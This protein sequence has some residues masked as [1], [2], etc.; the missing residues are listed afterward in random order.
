VSRVIRPA[1]EG[2]RDLLLAWR[3][4]PGDYRWY[5]SP[6]PVD[7]DTHGEWLAAR[8]AMEPPTL[9]VVEDDGTVCGSVRIDPEAGATGSVSVVV[10]PAARGRGIAAGLISHLDA[11]APALGLTRLEAVVHADNEPSR[12]LFLSAGY[13]PERTDGAFT[14]LVRTLPAG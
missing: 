7:P 6:E 14:V 13:V 1:A 9:W 5:G 11:V 10:D 3:N 4:D 2:D 8:L 12:R